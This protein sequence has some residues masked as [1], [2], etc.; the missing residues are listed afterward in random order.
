MY[1]LENHV[2]QPR[3]EIDEAYLDIWV[4]SGW[5]GTMIE[6]GSVSKSDRWAVF[7]QIEIWLGYPSKQSGSDLPW[8]ENGPINIIRIRW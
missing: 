6:Y 2:D 7:H 3:Y 1:I 5:V 8:A 4:L